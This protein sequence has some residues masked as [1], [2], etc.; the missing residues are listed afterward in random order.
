[1]LHAQILAVAWGPPGPPQGGQGKATMNKAR[2]LARVQP[3]SASL[4]ACYKCSHNGHM[5]RYCPK[6]QLDPRPCPICRQPRHWKSQCPHVG[7]F[8]MPCHGG[9]ASPTPASRE[10]VY[11]VAQVLLD[12]IIPW[13][14]IHQTIQTMGQPSLPVSWSTCQKLSTTP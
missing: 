10:I 2:V 3:K 9:P 14:G 13:F 4:E 11:V 5:A 12:Y 8:S 7:S 1:M 6:P